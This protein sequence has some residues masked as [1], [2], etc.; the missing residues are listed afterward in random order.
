MKKIL[1]L[2]LCI[3]IVISYSSVVLADTIE[4]EEGIQMYNLDEEVTDFGVELED[5]YVDTK[6]LTPDVLDIIENY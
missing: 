6:S 2:I 5:A 1:S 4:D 3:S